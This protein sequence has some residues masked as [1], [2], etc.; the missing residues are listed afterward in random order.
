MF[1]LDARQELL[2]R[3]RFSHWCELVV[4]PSVGLYLILEHQ[5]MTYDKSMIFSIIDTPH[6]MKLMQFDLYAQTKKIGQHVHVTLLHKG[7]TPLH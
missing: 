5:P 2:S 4:G 3:W 7:I 6:H 1:S